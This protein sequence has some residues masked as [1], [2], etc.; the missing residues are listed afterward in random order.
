MKKTLHYAEN[1]LLYAGLILY[2]LI[3]IQSLFLKKVAFDEIFLP[4]RELLHSINPEPFR[5]ITNYLNIISDNTDF[6]LIAEAKVNLIG[7][8]V[9]FFPLGIYLQMF[10]KDKRIFTSL[11]IVFLS[12]VAVE[13]IQYALGLGHC[14]IDDV[15]LNLLGGFIGILFYR[16]LLLI[17]KT[18]ETARTAVV[19]C[20]TFS[21]ILMLSLF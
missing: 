15:I 14:D 20:S 11:I 1:F 3:L 10:K 2:A 18:P 12:T 4:G 21:G 13:A 17:L 19:I 7:N 16:L 8:I 6:Q 9:L 5:T